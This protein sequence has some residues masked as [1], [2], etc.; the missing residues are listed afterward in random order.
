M[1]TRSNIEAAVEAG[2]YDDQYANYIMENCGGDRV[3]CNGDTLTIAIED[4]YLFDS[5]V[6]YLME[7]Q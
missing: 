7:Q 3:I 4:G 5:F 1:N 2:S 6:D